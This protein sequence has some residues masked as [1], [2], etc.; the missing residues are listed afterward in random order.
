L[1][2]NQKRGNRKHA[3][4]RLN[5]SRV[6]RNV[7]KFQ[8]VT[9]YILRLPSEDIKLSSSSL[10]ALFYTLSEEPMTNHKQKT[11]KPRNSSGFNLTDYDL[12]NFEGYHQKLARSI[13]TP[14]FRVGWQ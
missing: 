8:M 14:Y 2:N 13:K 3:G 4:K 9:D 5:Q 7:K 1:N 12:R 11:R 6:Q 10:D